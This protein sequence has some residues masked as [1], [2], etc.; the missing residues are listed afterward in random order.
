MKLAEDM[1]TFSGEVRGVTSARFFEAP[2]MVKH[3]GHYHLMYSSGKTTEDSYQVHHAVGDSPFGPFTEASNS[4]CLVTD[5]AKA[6]LSL[7]HHAV[8]ERDGRHYILYHRHSIPFDPEFIGR[9][10]C[11]DE[12][13]FGADG[14]IEK[15]N[16]THE[17]PPIIRRSAQTA[18]GVVLSASSQLAPHHAAGMAADDNHATLWVAAAD[19]ARAWLR[20]DPGR[21]T[22]IAC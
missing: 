21:E 7:G 14:F 4:P 18:E 17:G 12:L 10:I 3:G 2:F 9:Q 16:P 8:F 22:R 13:R 5:A 11:E 15:V 6:I 19:D 20:M 1:V